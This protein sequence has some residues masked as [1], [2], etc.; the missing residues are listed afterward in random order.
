MIE[1]MTE[2]S[3]VV[4]VS[5]ISPLRFFVIY[6]FLFHAVKHVVVVDHRCVLSR[7]TGLLF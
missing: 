7:F 4:I 2:L 1:V 6:L 3:F 5:F